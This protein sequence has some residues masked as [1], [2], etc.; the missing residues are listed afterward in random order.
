MRSCQIT[1]ISRLNAFFDPIGGDPI[2]VALHDDI[3]HHV[4]YTF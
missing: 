3:T 4:Y 1:S 2:G